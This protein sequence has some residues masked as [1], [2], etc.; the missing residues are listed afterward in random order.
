MK[1][2]FR[3]I[4][5]LLAVF[6]AGM[7]LPELAHSP[8]DRIDLVSRRGGGRVPLASRMA[9]AVRARRSSDKGGSTTGGGAPHPLKTALSLSLDVIQNADEATMNAQVE[10]SQPDSVAR[11]TNMR[12]GDMGTVAVPDETS[13][14]KPL[15]IGVLTDPYSLGTIGLSVYSTWA[16]EAQEFAT[17]I[18][19]I[20][21]CEADTTNFPGTVVCL[22]TPDTYP[23]QKKVF[24][25]WAYLWRHHLHEYK[26][27]M[28]VDHDTYVNVA[29][30]R[31]FL[32]VLQSQKYSQQCSY[33][34]MPAF[35]RAEEAKKLG[36]NGRPYCSGLGYTINTHCM[37][38]V[39]SHFGQCYE[40]TVSNHSDTEFGRCMMQHANAEC[41]SVSGFSFKQIYYQQSGDMVYPM[42]LVQGGQM[43][44]VFQKEPKATHF[45]AMLLHP[46]KRAEDFY[47]F[48][49]Q[50]MSALRP[51]QPAISDKSDKGPYRM[52]STDLRQSCVNNP[53]RQTEVSGFHL[54]ECS[55]VAREE[56]TEVLSEAF[57]LTRDTPESAARFRDIMAVLNGAGVRA[58]QVPVAGWLGSDP[59]PQEPAAQASQQDQEQSQQALFKVMRSLFRNTTLAGTR[60][61][62]ILQE[63]VMFSCNFKSQLRQLLNSD[64]CS[65]HLYTQ[66]R[67]GILLLGAHEATPEGLATVET[68]RSDAF[69]AHG[70]IQAALCYNVYSGYSGLFAGIYHSATFNDILKWMASAS[71]SPPPFHN[72]FTHLADAGY[73]VRS[74]FPNLVLPHSR[75]DPLQDSSSL[76][77][78]RV[79]VRLRWYEGK[80]C[81][82]DGQPMW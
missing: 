33:I 36:L 56:E 66:R 11:E 74:A 28:K 26:W 42:K 53:R 68:D 58:I 12:E 70:N 48:H 57:V 35:G 59:A 80:Y 18:F 78:A 71:K 73:V 29:E 49:K 82:P 9:D 22:D 55:A 39:G 62:M 14:K 41:S 38:A 5:W 21:S 34:G 54:P 77:A 20:G 63:D 27:F 4:A 76:P 19:F 7:L 32:G 47:R 69:A 75:V 72:V 16:R 1:K 52:A 3:T 64:R 67:G 46:L 23:P 13:G 24:L 30:M 2:H 6:V 61:V 40:N 43:T 51:V 15:L 65:S 50:S 31:G 17:V 37:N 45:A 79:A 10:V 8:D 81:R 60:R 25:M 44:L